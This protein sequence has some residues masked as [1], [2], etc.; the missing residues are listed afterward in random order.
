MVRHMQNRRIKEKW[1]K[2]KQWNKSTTK[3]PKTQIN[4]M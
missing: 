4:Y 1:V 2:K 3:I